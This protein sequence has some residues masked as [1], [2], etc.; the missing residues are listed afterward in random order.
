MKRTHVVQVPRTAIGRFARATWLIT[1]V[2]ALGVVDALGAQN[3]ARAGRDDERMVRLDT[4]VAVERGT[5]LD[6]T[7]GTGVITVRGWDRAEVDVRA[8]SE[9]GEF[10]FSKSARAVRLEARRTTRGRS[11]DVTIEVRVPMNTRVVVSNTS[12]DVHVL[13]V[14]GEVD[15]NLLNGDLIIRGASGRTAVTNVNGEIRVS[16]VDGPIKVQ[17]LTGEIVLADIRGDVNVTS[18]VGEVSMSGIQANVVQAEVVQG[19]I[20][21]D[22]VLNPTGRYEF[23]THSGDVHLFFAQDAGG[24]LNL[25]SFSG[26]LHSTIPLIVQPDSSSGRALPPAIRQLNARGLAL[27]QQR[28]LQIGGGGSAVVSVTTF[29]GDVHISRGPR[30]IQKEN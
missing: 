4:T 21:F 12:G 6:V 23:G 9:A 20:S 22:G 27:N 24:I 28:R 16:D 13:D 18:N 10:L 15:A 17:S 11:G 25:Q 2:V 19:E 8:Q 29:N 5:I 14:R 7:A 30:R 26:S 1:A 3:R